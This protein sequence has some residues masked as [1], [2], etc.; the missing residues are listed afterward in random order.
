[1]NI[2][3]TLICLKSFSI[4]NHI[5]LVKYAK[6][7]NIHFYISLVWIMKRINIESYFEYVASKEICKC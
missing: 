2:K 3:Y 6:I 7:C 1:M 4:R 5:N